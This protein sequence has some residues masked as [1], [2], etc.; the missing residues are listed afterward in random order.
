MP[1][2]IS[3]ARQP[4]ARN[5]MYHVSLP[6][7]WLQPKLPQNFHFWWACKTFSN[8]PHYIFHRYWRS[9]SSFQFSWVQVPKG[10]F[11]QYLHFYSVSWAWHLWQSR[12][13][14][15]FFHIHKL[16]MKPHMYLKYGFFLK[17]VTW[18]RMQLLSVDHFQSSTL[19]GCSNPP[20]FDDWKWSTDKRC[21]RNEVTS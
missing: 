16:G 1:M 21:T 2:L 8:L 12:Y 17:E 15:R 10:A 11:H 20:Y 13:H 4:A 5:N 7:L 14:S 6:A 9:W 18:L 19:G 3:R